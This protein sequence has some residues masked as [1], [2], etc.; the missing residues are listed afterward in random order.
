MIGTSK[1]INPGRK[2]K[3]VAV[4]VAVAAVMVAG[5]T[6]ASAHQSERATGWGVSVGI[7][8]GTLTHLGVRVGPGARVVKRPAAVRP[9]ARGPVVFKP[10]VY[11]P[12]KKLNL[13]RR[14]W[15]RNARYID[16][17]REHRREH[18]WDNRQ[19]HRRDHRHGDG[20]DR[21]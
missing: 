18:R 15:R 8:D 19:D 14:N 16:Q 17:R 3:T 7:A 5:T 6:V 2:I 13:H 20:R 4:A 21:W 1:K 10:H 11:G 12:A 9:W